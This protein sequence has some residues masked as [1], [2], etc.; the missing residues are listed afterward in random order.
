[1]LHAQSTTFSSTVALSSQLFDRG[2]AITGHTPILQGAAAWTF[3]TGWSLGVSAGAAAHSPG[4]L[5]EALAQLSRHWSLSSDW[6]L[7]ASLL[8]YR[9]PG[10]TRYGASDRIETGLGGTYRDVLTVGLSAIYVL[11]PDGHR[12]R[13]AADVNLHW[14]LAGRFSF[15]AGT[16]VAQ[17]LGASYRPRRYGY[18]RT[19]G[20]ARTGLTHYGHVGLLWG[21]GPWRIELDRIF[22]DPATRRQWSYQDASP[23]VATVSRSF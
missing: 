12:P 1:M 2:Q 10:T 21:D 22:A 4:R 3:P 11:G 8:Y 19:R 17:S 23:W 15:S 13:G 16:G 7:Q 14:P 9:Y 5:V 6:Q 18:W 20:Q